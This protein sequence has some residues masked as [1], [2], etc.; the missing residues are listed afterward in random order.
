MTNIGIA[1]M[2]DVRLVVTGRS[3]AIGDIPPGGSKSARVNPKGESHLLVKYADA[4]GNDRTLEI[5]C[6]LE[7]GYTGFIRMD[8]QDAKLARVAMQVRP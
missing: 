3:Y 5:D 2:R 7:P 6:Y 4:S 1:S 8:V